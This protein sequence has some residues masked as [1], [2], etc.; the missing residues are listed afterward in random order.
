MRKRIIESA[1]STGLPQLD[2]EW[3]DLDRVAQVEVT[4]AARGGNERL[5][6]QVDMVQNRAGQVA[7]IAKQVAVGELEVINCAVQGAFAG[8]EGRMST[9]LAAMLVTSMAVA[10]TEPPPEA[11]AIL[12]TLDGAFD[13]ALTVTV[14][15]G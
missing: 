5:K 2:K 6:S 8:E 14:M 7:V 9:A 1:R 4:E 3:M 10:F 12:V 11:V 13:A 15:D